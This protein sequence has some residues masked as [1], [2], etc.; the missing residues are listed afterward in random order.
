MKIREDS[1]IESFLE[2]PGP[3]KDIHEYEIPPELRPQGADPQKPYLAS[4]GIYIFDASLIE[5]VMKL[6]AND[7]GKEII[8]EVVHTEKVNAY[9]FDGYWEDIGTIKNFYD[10]NIALTDINPKVQFLR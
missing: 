4:M 2:K 3:T 5:E 10:A 1:A 7:F 8:P 6:S 9:V